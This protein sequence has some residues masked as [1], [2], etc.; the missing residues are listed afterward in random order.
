MSCF[1][2]QREFCAWLA[3][4]QAL[5]PQRLER[6]RAAV[7]RNTF[8]GTLVEALAESFPVTRAMAGE[9]FFHA[10]ARERV[11]ADPP[12]SPVL[13]EYAISF[14]DF[15]EGF[16]AAR[17]V[18]VLAEM[19]RLEALRLQSFHASDA[20]AVGLAEFHPLASDA[21][22]LE[23]TGVALHPAARWLPARHALLA[24]WQ[25]HADAGD[26]A[27]VDLG[28]IDASQPQ[29][30]LVHRPRFEVGM[31]ALPAGGV[32]FLEALAAGASFARAFLEAARAQPQ[33]QPAALFSL[34]LQ[35]GLVT[36]FVAVAPDLP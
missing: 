3:S 21:A 30:L 24:L 16:A 18:P 33:S 20:S 8:V 14:P 27:T 29:E 25:A 9:E 28:G 11:L 7:H 1:E 31:Q 12:R 32:T 17:T 34:L 2:D 19:A 4:E 23:V 6:A 26:P 35:Q 13:V 36:H 10:M 15:V 5:P 22:L